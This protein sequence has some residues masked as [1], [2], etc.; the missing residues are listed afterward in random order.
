MKGR[1]WKKTTAGLLALM[2]VTGSLP[3]NTPVQDLFSGIVLSAEAASVPRSGFCGAG[4]NEGGE[5]SVTWALDEEG[6]LTISGS[7]EMASY[8]TT[9][10]PW[11]N[12]AQNIKRVVIE[13]GVTS[14]GDTAFYYCQNLASVDIPDSVTSIGSAAFRECSSL[15]S[16]TIPDSVTSIEDGAFRASG[17]TSV[18]IPNSVTSIEDYAF[19]SCDKMTQI[20]IPDSVT[21][22]GEHGLAVCKSLTSL[23]IPNSVTSIGEAAISGCTGLTSL[24]IPNSMT[25][26]PEDFFSRC[27]SLTS[28]TIPDSITSIEKNA[29]NE[30]SS[31]TSIT[32]PDSVTSIEDGA[33]RASGLTSVT[34]PDSV[35][36]IGSAAFR[37]CSS[38]SSVTIP[39]SHTSIGDEVFYRCTSLTSFTIPDSVTSIGKRTFCSCENLTS[40]TIPNSVISIGDSAFWGC[41]LTSLTI[42]D[43]VTSI[44]TD[45]LYACKSLTMV[46]MEHKT[47]PTIGEY[48]LGSNSSGLKI[49][50]PAAS[51][52]AYQ[53]AENWSYYKD[54]L[55]QDGIAA[56]GICGNPEENN[57]ENVTYSLYRG[58]LTISGNGA[59]KDYKLSS[60]PWKKYSSDITEAV[61]ENGV[62]SIGISAFEDCD[63][64][65]SVTVPDSV[66]SIGDGAF[67]ECTHLASVN[68]PDNVTRIGNNTFSSCHSLKSITIP[69]SV[70]SIGSGAFSICTGLTSL[71]IPENVTSIGKSAFENCN[72]LTSIIIPE[73]V[74]SIG[75]KAFHMCSNLTSVNIP[76]GVTGLES[77]VFADCSSLTSVNIP[78]GVTSLES[79]V[80]A[81]C[82]S[83]TSVNIPNGVTSIGFSAVKG[84]SSLTSVNIPNGVTSL[85][86]SVFDGCSSLTSVN[87]PNGVTSI[88]AYAF[89]GCSSLTSFTIPDSVE[90]IG[91]SAFRCCTGLTS[92][93]ISDGVTIIDESA[94]KECESLTAVTLPNSVTII[95]AYVFMGCSSL[96]SVTLSESLTV[97]THDAFRSCA[98]TS[99][100]IPGSVTNIGAGAFEM[101]FNL[102]SVTIPGSVTNIGDRAFYDC[103]A[104][105]TVNVEAE[106]SVPELGEYVFYYNDSDANESR[107]IPDVRICVPMNTSVN[108]REMW[109]EYAKIIIE[110]AAL[111]EEECY[112]LI[113]GG[114][115]K[116]HVG[117]K[118]TVPQDSQIVDYG[119][120]YYNS[121]NVIHTEHLTLG[122][123]GVCGIKKAKYWGA[124]I[125]DNGSGVTCVGFVTL[126]NQLGVEWTQYTGEL[127][128]SFAE[129]TNA[130]KYVTLTRQE[131]KAVVSNGKNKVNVGFDANV[132]KGYTVEDYGLIYYNSGDVIHTEHLTLNNVGVCG[133]QK[134]KYWSAKIT[135]NGSGVTAV[136]FVTVKDGL[137]NETTLYTE[138]LGGSYTALSEEAAA[139]AV[140][141]TRRE[142]KAVVS[143]DKNKVYA[144][145]DANI[146]EGYTVEDYGLLYYNSGNVIHTEHLTLENVGVCGIQKA[147]FWGA[148]ITDNGYGVVCVGFV[149]VKDKNGYITTLYTEELGG[150]FAALSAVAEAN[151]ANAVTLTRHANKAVTANGKNKVYCGFTA[152][153]AA[154]YTVE[155]YG[156]LYYNSGNVIHTEHLVLENDGV[157][158]IQNAK[159]WSANITDK[160]YG[161][162][163][164]GFVKVKDA[165]GYVTTLY[166]G[167]LGAKFS[168]LPH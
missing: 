57:G 64:L 55:K 73:N 168:E 166:T 109:S 35:T 122:N 135:D 116:V 115:N 30:C 48:A 36:S 164:V 66:T 110:T 125:T 130:A 18:T 104:L 68:I 79:S 32:I 124:N 77:Y 148:N 47:P 96:A 65:T 127:G 24:V 123:V 152:N 86:S 102:T 85:E 137:G 167:E 141:L 105:K 23:T 69:D 43:N 21:S 95:G 138:E 155:N 33:F 54:N 111:T 131:P 28:V 6:T 31:L 108:Y 42:P 2:L 74:T 162:V 154:G 25:S 139:N 60:A 4:T 53:Q 92:L 5:E 46:I 62:T 10:S 146:A 75:E 83:L 27:T 147:T 80:F 76:N 121:G 119:L 70:T 94:F 16:V 38:L 63:H 71:T 117:F 50:V 87:I 8:Y 58:V 133:I 97:I 106:E 12:N 34:I 3:A 149:K 51:L 142:N 93:T 56:S 136:G 72:K 78:N 11:K 88:G 98:L 52:E 37:E 118:A 129:M 126:K 61:I 89:D 22:I 144:G 29:F 81:G 59:M 114:A 15:S 145:F 143:K 49:Y 45:V 9:G 13:N 113:S 150:N 90:S 165:N 132:P 159:Y 128:G 67:R 82:S 17:L 39:D 107:M 103:T 160:G 26:I 7:G 99:V 44:G 100:N 153:L 40:I 112:P 20:T 19:Y 101:C 120:L 1:F 163:C 157:C 161:V 134:A 140:T 158:G 91:R 84:C 14:I 156:L 41:G 151:A